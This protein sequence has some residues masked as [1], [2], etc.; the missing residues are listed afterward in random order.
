MSDNS[1]IRIPSEDHHGPAN[2]DC[3][4]DNSCK[5][6]QQEDGIHQCH[7]SE[8]G[9]CDDVT[10]SDTDE[11][12]VLPLRVGVVSSEDK[13]LTV[14]DINAE[15][16]MPTAA[17]LLPMVSTVKVGEWIFTREDDWYS[18]LVQQPTGCVRDLPRVVLA[19]PPSLRGQA[20]QLRRQPQPHLQV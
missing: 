9:L 11:D 8:A 1:N 7:T 12:I 18:C 6:C 15:L 10:T 5:P 20:R 19:A 14:A 16:N 4:T 3:Y 2:S 13:L 17:G